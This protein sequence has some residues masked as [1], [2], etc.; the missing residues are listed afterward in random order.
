MAFSI[1]YGN[2]SLECEEPTVA[3]QFPE[4]VQILCPNLDLLL[5]KDVHVQVYY[6]LSGEFTVCETQ[7]GCVA[8]KWSITNWTTHNLGLCRFDIGHKVTVTFGYYSTLYSLEHD[9]R[10]LCEK[11]R[12]RQHFICLVIRRCINWQVMV[13]L[14][15]RVL[16]IQYAMYSAGQTQVQEDIVLLGWQRFAAVEWS[17]PLHIEPCLLLNV[18]FRPGVSTCVPLVKM[19]NSKPVY[20]SSHV[21]VTGRK[22]SDRKAR[23]WKP[24]CF[25]K[26]AR[27]LHEFQPEQPTEL[28]PLFLLQDIANSE[29]PFENTKHGLEDTFNPLDETKQVN[30]GTAVPISTAVVPSVTESKLLEEEDWVITVVNSDD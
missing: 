1:V 15:S 4:S 6:A 21:M 2:G 27:Q 3:L 16:Q 11:P 20:V 14:C 17:A 26:T 25:S 10:L 12:Y 19:F 24:A 5:L 28:E 7:F 8:T 29:N 23:T 13:Q 18:P 9:M 22:R 30:E